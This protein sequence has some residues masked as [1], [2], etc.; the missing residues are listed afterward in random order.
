MTEVAF[1]QPVVV[2]RQLLLSRG[3]RLVAERDRR[4]TAAVVFASSTGRAGPDE[5]E[6]D[7]CG[8]EWG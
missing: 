7:G 4:V 8:D 6:A 3:A 1:E 5:G 2:G